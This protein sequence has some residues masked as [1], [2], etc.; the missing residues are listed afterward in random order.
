[1]MADREAVGR[2]AD[3]VWRAGGGPSGAAHATAAEFH[4]LA[5]TLLAQ[6]SQ[7]PLG[8]LEHVGARRGERIRE[9]L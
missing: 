7:P 2:A 4:S 9:T 3:G 5:L 8:Q 6:Q 1:M